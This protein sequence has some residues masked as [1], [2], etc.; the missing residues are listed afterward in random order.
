V[1][2]WGYWMQKIKLV[3]VTAAW[4]SLSA[5]AKRQGFQCSI[6]GLVFNYLLFV[7]FMIA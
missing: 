6:I 5:F 7:L 4:A 1:E 3:I 2:P